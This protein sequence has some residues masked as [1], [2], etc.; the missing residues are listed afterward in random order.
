VGE[1]FLGSG[2]GLESAILNGRNGYGWDV[3]HESIDFCNKRL[4]KRLAER[5]IA[6]IDHSIAA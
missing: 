2:S 5:E 4:N 6:K 3:D 1:L